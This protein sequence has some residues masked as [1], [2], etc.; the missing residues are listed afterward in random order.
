MPGSGTWSFSDVSGFQASLG[1]ICTEFVVTHPGTFSARLTRTTL[2]HLHLMRAQEVLSRVAYVA[3]PPDRIYVSFSSQ[4]ALSLI[5]RG[6]TLDPGE[7]ILHSRGERLHQRTVGAGCWG[8]I[9]MPPSS[10]ALFGK[11]VTG[12]VL[13]LPASGQLLRP[14]TRELTQLVRVHG[15][16]AHLAETRPQTVGHP[17]IV[18]A[19]EQELAELLIFCL[20]DCKVRVETDAMKRVQRVMNS[21]EDFLATNLRANTDFLELRSGIGVSAGAFR[22]IC[23]AALGV[24]PGRYVQ[25]RRLMRVRAAII[26]A[27]PGRARLSELATSGGFNQPGRFAAL[28]RA[29]FGETPSATLRRSGKM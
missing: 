6:V 13:E 18:R 1:D 12:S 7:I 17:E 26:R 3:L 19:M 25:L 4:P 16:A 15:E 8:L 2:Q 10:L 23:A 24:G 22:D 20:A 21:F 11:A 29:A 9:S 28:Y 5:W 27:D 14:N